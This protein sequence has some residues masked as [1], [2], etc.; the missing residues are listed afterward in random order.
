MS[1]ARNIRMAATTVVPSR[2]A[3]CLRRVLVV[4][5]V[6]VFGA[7]TAGAET[8][9]ALVI[10]NGAYAYAGRLANPPGDAKLVAGSLRQLGFSVTELI[11]GDAT[12]MKR[13]M[14]EFGRALRSSDAVGL[15]YY[16]GHGLQV[17]GHNYLVPVN[18]NVTD[19]TEVGIET[20]S[21]SELL[22]TMERAKSGVNIVIL[23]A[24]RNNPFA[25]S[26]RSGQQG[27]A[28]VDAPTG[29]FVAY[30]TAPG[31]VAADGT[32]RNSPYTEAF[33]SMIRRQGLPIEQVF[34][35]VRRAVIAES[36]GRQ[37]PWDSSS[38]TGDFYFANAGTGATSPPPKPDAMPAPSATVA[39]VDDRA[40]ELALWNVVEANPSPALLLSFLQQFP[41][42]TFAAAARSRLA[43]VQKPPAA[44]APTA[45]TPGQLAWRPIIADS[46]RR[47]LSDAELGRL[48]CERLWAARNELFARNGYCFGSERGQRLFGTAGCRTSSQDILSALEKENSLAIKAEENRRCGSETAVLPHTVPS[49]PQTAAP[50]PGRSVGTH[51]VT[52]LNPK[53]D[54]FLSLKEAPDVDSRRLLKMG[55]DTPLEVIGRQGDWLQVRLADGTT[56]WAFGKYVA[57]CKPSGR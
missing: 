44:A 43:D 20:V 49:L 17:N 32:G 26:F 22:A 14:L 24:C 38:L 39:A 46:S 12:A 5:L 41:R 55:P 37:V 52:G 1:N 47:R 10:G 7:V 36:G 23:D 40:L 56:G 6:L 31:S 33:A 34:K 9:L 25:R 13:K 18:A 48:D 3:C 30:A 53:G 16:A 11:D 29:S 50:G 28:R 42:G 8:R 51:F 27:L 45:T 15:F 54:N 21:L 19:E 2:A 4:V 57:C 35:E